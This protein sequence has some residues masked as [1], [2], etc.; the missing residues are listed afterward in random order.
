MSPLGFA[1]LSPLDV[2]AQAIIFPIAVTH[3]GYKQEGDSMQRV[4]TSAGALDDVHM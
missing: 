2:G 1:V 4:A 3:F